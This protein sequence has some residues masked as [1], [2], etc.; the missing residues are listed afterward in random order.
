MGQCRNFFQYNIE[1]MP[2]RPTIADSG[3]HILL[4]DN[5][6]TVMFNFKFTKYLPYAIYD[7]KKRM[8]KYRQHKDTL[9]L[10]YQKYF[11]NNIDSV[12]HNM[13]KLYTKGVVVSLALIGKYPP[14]ET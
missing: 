14:I 4:P 6:K 11:K 5:I 1:C 9:M 2:K 8:D 3:N 10:D 13:V 12:E 7:C